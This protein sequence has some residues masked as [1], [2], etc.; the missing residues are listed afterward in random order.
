M[1]GAP[2]SRRVAVRCCVNLWRGAWFWLL[3][4][5]GLVW[6]VLGAL[7][8]RT[9][10]LA[11]RDICSAGTRKKAKTRTVRCLEETFPEPII[12]RRGG[13]PVDLAGSR[14]LST[15]VPNLVVFRYTLVPNPGEGDTHVLLSPKSFN[16]VNEY[17]RV[18]IHKRH[19]S[20]VIM[21]RLQVKGTNPPMQV[22][23]LYLN[24]HFI[25]YKGALLRVYCPYI[26]PPKTHCPYKFNS[27]PKK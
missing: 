9:P 16:S 13:L 5:A 24:G 15:R 26:F 10:L 4:S 17:S 1:D 7:S 20:D 2:R 14:F 22:Q 6:T 27:A 23:I 3:S 8:A 11:P 12:Y 18:P 25:Q 19:F 21:H